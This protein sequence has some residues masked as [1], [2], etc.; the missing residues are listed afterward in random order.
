MSEKVK[1]IHIR[2][3]ADPSAEQM[4]AAYAAGMLQKEVLEHGAYYQG[5]CRNAQVARWHAGRQV[6]I[7]WRSKFGERF[8]EEIR[9]PEDE[10][11]YDAFIPVAKVE[12]TEESR[13]P[14]ERFEAGG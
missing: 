14:D 5:H 8:L 1:G 6:F 4:A 7:H 10:R 3:P 12:P 11:R 13:I 9:H 2:L